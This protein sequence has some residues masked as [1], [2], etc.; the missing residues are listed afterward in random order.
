VE[1]KGSFAE[2]VFL[3]LAQA[4]GGAE[5]EEVGRVVQCGVGRVAEGGGGGEQAV[6]LQE[7]RWCWKGCERRHRRG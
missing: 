5:L 4:H 3:F 1:T 7:V 6:L 2:M